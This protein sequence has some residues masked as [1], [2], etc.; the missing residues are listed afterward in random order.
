MSE[1][2]WVTVKTG[3]PAELELARTILED[4]GIPTRLPEA[5]DRHFGYYADS[6]NP[7]LLPLQVPASHA[8][9]A[10]RLLGEARAASEMEAS[11]GS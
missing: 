7:W 3:K 5:P 9:E 1:T 8:E 6:T 11:E 10:E 4:A 2:E